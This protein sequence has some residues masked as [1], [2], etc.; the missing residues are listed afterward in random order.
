MRHKDRGVTILEVMLAF[1]ILTIGIGFMLLSNKAY[2]GFRED[3]QERQQ[4]M[5]Y[6][7]G[8]M[9]AIL[10][11]Q[12]VSYNNPPFDKYGVNPTVTDH[13]TNEYLQIIRIDVFKIDSPD[14]PDPVSIYTYRVKME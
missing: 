2:Y 3:R 7:A 14:D 6:A 13:S 10:E 8:Q 12:S 4:M 11:G 5:F 9:D 1:I